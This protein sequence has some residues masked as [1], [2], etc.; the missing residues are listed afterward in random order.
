MTVD[1]Y[2]EHFGFSE[3][4][5]T[6]SPDPDMLFWTRSHKRA[7]SILEYGLMTHAPL[8]VVTGEVGTGKT[9]LVQALLRQVEDDVVIGLIS[10]AQGGRDDLLR[11]VLNALELTPAAEDTYVSLFQQFQDFVIASYAEGKRV[12][13]IFDEAQNLGPETLEELRMLTNI[14]SGKDELLQL[15]LVGQPELRT[16]IEKPELRQFAQ[17]VT[18][19]YHLNPLDRATTFEYVQ[20]RLRAVGGSGDE[21]TPDAI[22]MIS[23]Q[24]AGIPRIINKI[25]DLALVYAASADDK[26]VT[27]ETIAELVRDGVILQT[28]TG[29]LFLTER[30]F[31]A[32]K[33]AE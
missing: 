13:L 33:A 15:I 26:Q 10:N 24:S 27:A 12:I 21:I 32:G 18:S 14:N 8:T 30:V 23:G 16:I 11:W 1:L 2:C 28:Y 31:E 19:T 9:T 6:L 17:R 29:P 7:Y 4:P 25:C 3:R 20:H 5:F 22:T